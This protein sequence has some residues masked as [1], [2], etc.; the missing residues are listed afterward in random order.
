MQ[1]FE[2]FTGVERRRRWSAEDKCRIVAETREPGM[3][4]AKVARRHDIHANQIYAWRRRYSG[5][6]LDPVL[7]SEAAAFMPVT[8][9]PDTAPAAAGGEKT[10]L[11]G[12]MEIVLAN[13]RL[14][15]VDRHVDAGA[16][17][18]ILSVLEER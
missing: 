14:V 8:V 3:T 16:L 15:R 12:L 9:V 6:P 17:R 18:R 13:G 11:P 10:E 4:V 1:R 5:D 2:V 7:S